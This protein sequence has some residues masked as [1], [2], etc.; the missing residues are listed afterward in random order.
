MENRNH[1]M[2]NDLY[3]RLQASSAQL[4]PEMVIK[5]IVKTMGGMRV[6]IPTLK[7]LNRLQR[8]TRIRNAFHGGNYG[9]LSI[10]FGITEDMV[11]KIVHNY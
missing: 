1:K 5:I 3:E 4:T 7:H 9:E 10:R 6:C 8:N 2:L 11:R